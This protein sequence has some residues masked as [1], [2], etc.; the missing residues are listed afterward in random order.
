MA[1]LKEY[2]EYVLNNLSLLLQIEEECAAAGEELSQEAR[3]GPLKAAAVPDLEEEEAAISSN[4]AEQVGM[5]ENM[6]YLDASRSIGGQL[7]WI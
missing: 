2:V 1:T 6:I 3:S 5:N 7:Q 4:S